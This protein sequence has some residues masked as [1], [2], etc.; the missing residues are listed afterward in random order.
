MNQFITKMGFCEFPFRNRTAEKENTKELFV[1]PENYE[2]LLSYFKDYQ[3][4][5]ISGD[6]GTGK[7]IILKDLIEKSEDRLI[8]NIEICQRSCQ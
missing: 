2:M 1:T 4:C 6:R 3:T 5:I 7:T 8:V